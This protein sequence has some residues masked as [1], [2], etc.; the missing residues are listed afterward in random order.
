MELAA[1][2]DVAE[3][4]R[5][6][7]ER[8]PALRLRR[9]G[10]E[11]GLRHCSTEHCAALAGCDEQVAAPLSIDEAP[12][13]PLEPC[14]SREGS[15]EANARRLNQRVEAAEVHA[16]VLGIERGARPLAGAP[17]RRDPVVEP[18]SAAVEGGR[19]RVTSKRSGNH[20]SEPRSSGT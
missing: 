4:A 13:R 11:E 6:R 16:V 12:E 3:D 20:R 1:D 5:I 14:P 9:F 19:G 18:R 10:L 7:V 15:G 17:E 8:S 2:G